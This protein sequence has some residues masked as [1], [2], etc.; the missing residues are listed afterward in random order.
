VLERHGVVVDESE[1]L[2]LYARHEARQESA[3]GYRRYRAVLRGV[4]AGV[5]GELGFEPTEA[6]LEAL[7]DSIGSW[8]PFPDTVDALR[9][10]HSRYKLAVVSNVDDD[11]FAR[12]AETLGTP[13]DDVI[14]AQ[15]VGS[16]KPSTANFRFAL[17][18]L[19]V[20]RERV[21]HVAQSLY[22]DHVPAKRLGL[23]TVWINRP[24]RRAGVGVAP[25][26][27]ARP[28]LEFPDLRGLVEAAGL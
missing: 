18:R 22:H 12:T 3:E 28:D 19:G 20:T 7:A 27:S 1:I 15:Q 13:F 10:L 17:A 11:L 23:A 2:G 4:M 25:P 16:Y 24:S 6:D 26:A 21:L 8:P 9:R 14:T 5:A